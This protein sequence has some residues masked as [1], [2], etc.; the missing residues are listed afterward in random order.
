[1]NRLNLWHLR[2]LFAFEAAS[3]SMVA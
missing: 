2:G 3:R 1:M